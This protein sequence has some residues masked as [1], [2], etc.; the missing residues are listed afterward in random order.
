M[1]MASPTSL[2]VT[3]GRRMRAGSSHGLPLGALERRQDGGA[4]RPA[5]ELPAGAGACDRRAV[6]AQD[7]RGVL[8]LP[9]EALGERARP[10]LEAQLADV[11]LERQCRAFRRAERRL[12]GGV[13]L[14]LRPERRG[15]VAPG[16]G[17]VGD[18]HQAG[19]VLPQCVLD[20]VRGHAGHPDAR[21]GDTVRD[22]AVRVCR[23]GLA[24]GFL[25]PGRRLDADERHRDHGDQGHGPRAPARHA[26]L[27][28][29][30]RLASSDSVTRR[31]CSR[32]RSPATVTTRSSVSA[33]M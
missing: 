27:A 10:A 12:D 6:V 11:G 17:A 22:D 28:V 14:R 18:D 31:S 5:G 23:M 32:F 4:G 2:F 7:D 13:H 29:A 33:Q 9:V 25:G 3:C 16:L 20:L 26:V 21:D 24:V 1:T 8:A 19:G 15:P 30:Q